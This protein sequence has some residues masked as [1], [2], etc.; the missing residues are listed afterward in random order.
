MENSN[1]FDYSAQVPRHVKFIEQANPSKNTIN[2]G[3]RY[4]TVEGDPSKV[5]WLKANKNTF[6]TTTLES[7]KDRLDQLETSSKN[8][9]NNVGIQVLD[10]SL[11]EEPVTIHSLKPSVRLPGSPEKISI[12]ERMQELGIPG[13]RVAIFKNGNVVQQGYG[14]LK[15]SHTLVQAASI[16]K[17]ITALTVL[18]LIEK[19]E[20]K[21][22]VDEDI[23]PLLGNIWKKINPD[24]TKV[25]IRQLLSHTAGIRQD[26]DRGFEGYGKDSVLPDIDA[27]LLGG[28]GVNSDPVYLSSTPGEHYAYSGGGTMIL[29]KLIE[30]ATEGDYEKAVNENVFNKL[31]LKDS[32]FNLSEE[33]ENR[34]SQGYGE[35]YMPMADKWMRQPELAAAGLWT[36]AGDLAEVAIE[37]QNALKG[38]GS[39]LGKQLAHE[40]IKPVVFEQRNPAMG[41]FVENPENDVTYFYHDGSNI[42]FRCLMVANNQ[43]EGAVIMIN[44]DNGNDI[45]PELVR[46]IAE[47]NQWQA[48]NKLNLGFPEIPEE[49]TVANHNPQTINIPKW[50]QENCGKYQFDGESLDIGLKDDPHTANFIEITP[51][52]DNVGCFRHKPIGLHHS[53]IFKQ[54]E[55]GITC[56]KE[57]GRGRNFTNTAQ[58]KEKFLGEYADFGSISLKEDGKIYAQKGDETFEIW[59]MSDGFRDAH[60]GD[61]QFIYSFTHQDNGSIGLK[62][63]V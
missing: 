43:G 34:A 63:E 4:Y 52:G 12:E 50:K 28:N 42:G 36:T 37:I 51:L 32:G 18:S 45:I 5:D 39:I 25:T 30:I 1:P 47:E 19:N 13:I 48:G 54:N 40:M 9:V 29:Q 2:V 16:S 53:A 11:K 14:E 23:G 57:D 7:I 61:P 3:G 58:W 22:T 33:M 21:I 41:L 10:T 59:P 44:S 38:K 24:G 62:R 55:W 26:G 20:I 35:D 27:I 15:S 17:T 49:L 46:S 8:R 31:G 60:V 6:A 56:Y